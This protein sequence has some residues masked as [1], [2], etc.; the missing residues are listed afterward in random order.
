M[1]TV[2]NVQKN[3]AGHKAMIYK[4]LC[5]NLIR[6]EYIVTTSSKASKAQPL[7]EK[8]LARALK[9]NSK[10]TE[11]PKLKLSK[12]ASLEYLQP[13]DKASVGTKVIN[14]LSKRYANRTHGFTRIIKLEPRLGED[15]APMSV[16]EL[17]D[18]KYEVKFWYIAKTVARLE[19]QN[20]PLD[21]ITEL[22]MKKLIANRHNGEQVFRD[23]VETCKKE[24]FRIKDDSEPSDE[25]MQKILKN[26]PNMERHTGSLKGK[27]LVSKKYNV[28]PRRE[29]E[30][31]P[32]PQ[33]PYLKS[34]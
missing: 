7:I 31:V 18:S 20:V 5:A 28:R 15:K 1:V 25:K 24:F 27:L 2:N 34:T 3:V 19:L 4:N 12:M 29:M 17:V 13:P 21:D 9:E 10:F 14:E 11:D 6:N 22:N 8:F 16:L 32:L 33:S 30:P 26:L 23:A